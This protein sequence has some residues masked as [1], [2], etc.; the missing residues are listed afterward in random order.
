[1]L[2]QVEALIDENPALGRLGLSQIANLAI[3]D[4]AAANPTLWSQGKGQREEYLDEIKSDL[5]FRE[6]YKKILKKT[7]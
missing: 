4:A 1:M 2:E 3:E 6:R 7:A 5:R